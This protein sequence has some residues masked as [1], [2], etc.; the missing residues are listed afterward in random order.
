[1]SVFDGTQSQ[2]VDLRES[3]LN[4]GFHAEGAETCASV[5]MPTS[6]PPT[7]TPTGDIAMTAFAI[8]APASVKVGESS[9]VTLAWTVENLGP[10]PLEIYYNV[11]IWAEQGCLPWRQFIDG[12]LLPVLGEL[13][14]EAVVPFSCNGPFDGTQSVKI[15]AIGYT[16]PDQTFSPKDDPNPYN[17]GGSA[18]ATVTV[19]GIPSTST[20]TPTPN[21]QLPPLVPGSAPDD[22]TPSPVAGVIDTSSTGNNAPQGS[23]PELTPAALAA[24][25]PKTGE[26]GRDAVPG[27]PYLLVASAVAASVAGLAIARWRLR[28]GRR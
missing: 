6:A 15:D 14:T 24:A 9:N 8:D 13:R 19:I 20:P 7:T 16:G 1:V 23:A 3:E 26:S 28:R 21:G 27:W 11:Q 25:L 12:Q 5:P 2:P 10:D 17:N 4:S 22:A 18:H